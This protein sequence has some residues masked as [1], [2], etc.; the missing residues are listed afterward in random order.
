MVFQKAC[1]YVTSDI[2]QINFAALRTRAKA[3][4]CILG[5]AKKG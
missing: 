3:I 5:T 1:V 2:I 4:A